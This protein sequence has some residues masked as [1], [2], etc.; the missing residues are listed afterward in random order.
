MKGD[1]LI[2]EEHHYQAA[3]KIV[4]KIIGKIEINNIGS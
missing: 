1:V 4:E 3:N 2:I